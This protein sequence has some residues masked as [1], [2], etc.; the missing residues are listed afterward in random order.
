M[1]SQKVSEHYIDNEA[2]KVAL[3]EYAE[4]RKVTIQN[5]LPEPQVSNYIAMCFLKIAKGVGTKHNFRN[6]SYLD[7]MI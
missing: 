1:L 5:N 4:Q 7:D 6:Y 3:K 2:F